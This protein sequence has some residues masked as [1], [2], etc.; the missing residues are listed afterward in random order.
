MVSG[1]PRLLP[2]SFHLIRSAL[3]L[4]GGHSAYVPLWA[5]IL[6]ILMHISN[7]KGAPAS[8]VIMEEDIK[9]R[10]PDLQMLVRL[11][12]AQCKHKELSAKLVEEF[13]EVALTYA[14]ALSH[15]ID[16]PELTLLARKRLKEFA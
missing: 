8:K 12:A 16:Y 5:P 15:R 14:T 11:Q 3:L 6:E 9:E 10:L 7:G 1:S 13:E 4:C 2:F